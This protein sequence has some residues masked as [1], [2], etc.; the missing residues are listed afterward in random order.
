MS[1]SLIILG[2]AIV[3]ESVITYNTT[4]MFFFW[5]YILTFQDEVPLNILLCL[6]ASRTFGVVLAWKKVNWISILFYII[7]YL[8]FLIRLVHLIFCTNVFGHLPISTGDCSV[9]RWFQVLSGQ[10]LFCAVELLLITRVYAFY[11]KNKKLLVFLFL[12]LTLEYTAILV[13]ILKS[14]PKGVVIAIPV[15]LIHIHSPPCIGISQ[16]NEMASLWAPPLIMQSILTGFVA[17]KCFK[18]RE[19]LTLM[20]PSNILDI[21]IRDHT[22]AFLLI[23]AVSLFATLSY[24][25]TDH[26][27][28][29]ALT[30]IL[31]LR[32]EEHKGS[33][34][35]TFED[36]LTGIQFG[37]LFGTAELHNDSEF[38]NVHGLEE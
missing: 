8:A 17:W 22:W 11:S 37:S 9:W 19:N 34:E 2:V 3:P 25:L 4:S 7:R 20:H 15:Q 21:F 24:E 36:N 33:G 38:T 16:P 27:G 23:F 35:D 32:I 30:L 6:T 1:S 31:N 14:L 29:V 26:L 13:I 18:T 5:D 12:L 28:E 10:L